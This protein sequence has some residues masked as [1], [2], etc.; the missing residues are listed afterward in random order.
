[1]KVAIYGQPYRT[2]SL[3]KPLDNNTDIMISVGGDG[4]MLRASGIIQG[5]DIPVIGINTGRMG[6]LANVHKEEMAEALE[7]LN[8]KQYNINKRA[9]IHVEVDYKDGTQ[10]DFGHA[11]NEV[12]VGRKNLTSMISIKTY[13]NGKYLNTY[14]ADGLIVST[15][16]GSTGYSLSCDGPIITP[17]VEAM[18]ITPIAPHNL[19]IRPLVIQG[20]SEITLE[21]S[22]REDEYLMSIDSRVESLPGN[23]TIINLKKSDTCIN[24][25]ELDNH[26]FLNTLREKLLWGKDIRH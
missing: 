8:N 25:I 12:T 24:M 13:L 7:M 1:M 9:L 5:T 10:K 15:P 21:V 2:S 14:W 20:D 4:T 26:H 3:S 16:T 6:F 11:L 22:S 23:T 19:S 18:V 17:N